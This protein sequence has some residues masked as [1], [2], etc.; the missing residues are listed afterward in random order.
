MKKVIIRFAALIVFAFAMTVY[1][2]ALPKDFEGI[3][4]FKITYPDSQ[5]PESQM[6][7]FPKIMTITIKGDKSKSEIITSM[8]TQ[9]EITDY[10]QKSKVGLINMMGQKFAIHETAEEIMKEMESQAKPEVKLTD[11]TKTV[12]GYLCR[13]AIVTVN[14]E[15]T[16]TT[17]D[18][19]YTDELGGTDVNFD[20]PVYKDIQGVLLEFSMST[21]QFTMVFTATDVEKKGVSAKEFEIP[22][23]YTITTRDELR[24]K[25]GGME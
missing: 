3:I 8:G 14:D 24:S 20:N 7:M 17:F 4:T 10:T 21:P 6:A 9:I 25:M 5:F 19:F 15:G 23:D 22:P 13:K 11:E 16:V 18:V 12:A 1:V 2:N